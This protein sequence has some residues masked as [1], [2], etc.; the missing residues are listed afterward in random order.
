MDPI[1]LPLLP[2]RPWPLPGI[3]GE[4]PGASRRGNLR[5]P[6]SLC[7]SGHQ[8]LS[9][10][11]EIPRCRPF[12]S[13][14]SLI[15]QHFVRKPFPKSEPGAGSGFGALPSLS[16][17]RSF[18]L[19]APTPRFPGRVEPPRHPQSRPR[20]PAP[21]PARGQ[22]KTGKEAPGKG[23]EAPPGLLSV[24][25]RING[26]Q[27]NPSGAPLDPGA[28]PEES[29]LGGF[30]GL[31]PPK[32][33]GTAGIVP[34]RGRWERDQLE[35]P[36]RAEPLQDSVKARQERRAESPDL[37]ERSFSPKNARYLCLGSGSSRRGRTQSRFSPSPSRAG[38]LLGKTAGKSPLSVPSPA[39]TPIPPDFPAPGWNS[40]AF[41]RIP[42]PELGLNG[43]AAVPGVPGCARG[44]G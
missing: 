35:G 24:R 28:P 10:S 25:L 38:T 33:P 39:P 20:F 18:P 44:W 19:P 27:K 16:R 26:T 13:L 30:C 8:N 29:E 22:Q 37:G 2:A 41:P 43:F 17:P 6:P 1:P 21:D 15:L 40:R 7:G 42:L 34:V 12:F 4:I 31:R 3:Q 32:S 23:L 36:F 5:I 14:P 9:C 11:P